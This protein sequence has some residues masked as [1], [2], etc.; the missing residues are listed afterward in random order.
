MGRKI[1]DKD[2]NVLDTAAKFFR[3]RIQGFFSNV[4][5][6]FAFH[7]SPTTQ[8]KRT[9]RVSRALFLKTSHDNTLIHTDTPTI[10]ARRS[11]LCADHADVTNRLPNTDAR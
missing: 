4:D 11:R 8:I 2:R 3:Q 7:P 10:A 6:F 1:L 9:Y 5:E